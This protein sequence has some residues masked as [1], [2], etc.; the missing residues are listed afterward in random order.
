[1]FIQFTVNKKLQLVGKLIRSEICVNG[2]GLE[3]YVH[4]I[5]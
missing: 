4:N 2:M 3:S 1:M 5:S